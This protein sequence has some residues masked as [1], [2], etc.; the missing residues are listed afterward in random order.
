MYNEGGTGSVLQESRELFKYRVGGILLISSEYDAYVLEEDGQLAEKIYHEFSDLSLPYIP[1]IHRV[2]SALE[3]FAV[4][5]KT[6]VQL[7]ISMSRINEAKPFALEEAI[8]SMYPHIPIV[9]LTYER[10]TPDYISEI[11][12][13]AFIDRV[14]YWSGDSKVLLAIIKYIEDRQNFPADSFMGVQAILLVEDSAVYYSQVLPLIYTEILSQTRY[15]V[16]HAMNTKHGLLRVRLRPKILLAET[17]EEAMAIIEKYRFQLLGI[18][19]DVSFPLAGKLEEKAGFR[20]AHETKKMVS[21]LPFLMESE[22]TSNEA[23]AVRQN[24]H[25][26][27]KTSPHLLHDVREYIL[28]HYGFGP[29]VFRDADGQVLGVANDITELE[30]EVRVL[31]GECLKLHAANNDFSRWFRARTEFAIADKLRFFD[32]EN[33]GGAEYLRTYI[34]NTLE[35][36]FKRYRTTSILNLDDLE[37]KDWQNS[38]L[39]LSEGSMGGKARGVAFMRALIAKE[40]LEERFEG[41]RICI[42]SSFV[43]GSDIF[44]QIVDEAR[45]HELL[46]LNLPEEEIAAEFL[47]QQLPPTLESNLRKLCQLVR[48]PLAV[49]S[50]SLL[51]D[52]RALPFAGIYRTYVVP[53]NSEDEEVRFRQL[54]TAIKLVYASVFYEIPLRYA[55]NAGL[56]IEEEKMAI[57]IQELVGRQFGELFYPMAAGVAQSYNFYPYAALKAEEGT[58]SIVLGFGKAVVEGERSLRFSPEQPKRNP[59]VAGARELVAA[60]QNFFYAVNLSA[61]GEANL[62]AGSGDFLQKYPIARALK[63]G[64][65]EYVGSVYSAENDCVYDNVYERGFPFVSFAPILKYERI[66]LAGILRLLLKGGRK[67]FGC[68]V[69]IE[70]ALKPSV[71]REKKHEFH[72]LQIRP[73]VMGREAQQTETIDQEDTWCYSEHAIGNIYSEE[74]YDLLVLRPENFNVLHTTKIAAEI[75]SINK[76]M[77]AEGRRYILVA[78]G[79][80]GS[81]DRFLG[82]PL[83]WEQM[84]EAKVII[85]V[86]LKDLHP[87]PSMGSH[88]FH[89]LTATGMGYFHIPYA[90][91]KSRIDWDWLDAQPAA[92]S[93]EYVRHIRS[94]TPYIV[95]IDGRKFQGIIKK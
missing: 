34:I 48:G 87:E 84:S 21:D 78:F 95:K 39:R 69:E 79:R 38:V 62:A 9:L 51:E 41:V 91:K 19:S 16:L 14:F 64:G 74:I 66:P 4:L 80:V 56:R 28:N 22:E 85:E 75:G 77:R 45:L 49:R 12:K 31:P 68:D 40:N 29:F 88:F 33:V 61:I 63:D 60:S 11:R 18:I 42:P 5:E 83:T 2:A 81:T 7:V 90:A 72:L 23:E 57:L 58:A 54:S 15:L 46:G 37:K 93:G 3:A 65:L 86:G 8:K 36:Y 73:M 76:K 20:L 10:M 24:I 6:S 59:L 17:Y 67:A 13:N 43:V 94:E 47:K 32:P 53:N 82:I 92:F 1:E 27:S 35:E 50:S 89:N 70:F 55:A 71:E 25:Y 52:S 30:N 44:E 26:L